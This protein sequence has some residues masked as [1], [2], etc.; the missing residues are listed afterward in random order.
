[1]CST[2]NRSHSAARASQAGIHLALCTGRPGFG[3]TRT[4][5]ERL[6]PNG[7]HAFQNGASLVRLS[8]NESR[9][10]SLRPETV[11]DIKNRS[12]RASR[13]LELYSDHCYA[14]ESTNEKARRNAEILGIPFEAR[15]LDAVA[16]P[17]VRA[18][19]I[20][21]AHELDAVMGE[22]HQGFELG[23][24][25]GP[26]MPDTCFVNLTPPGIDKGSAIRKLCEIH[27][28]SL[29]DVMFVGDGLNDLSAMSIVGSPV[30]MGNAGPAVQALARYQ[31]DD[32]DSGGLA[33]ALALAISEHVSARSDPNKAS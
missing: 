11:I 16:W 10:L 1:M 30:A 25:T 31:V 21:P 7:W 28:C 14:V 29:S 17:V 2:T 3:V 18:Q 15:S 32:V 26:D 33:D 5:A 22:P 27:G 8:T 4:Y 9:S 23:P 12:Q 24:S 19:W 20:I 6:A 13:I